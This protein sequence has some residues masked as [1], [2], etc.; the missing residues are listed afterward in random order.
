MSET[1]DRR[2]FLASVL[3]W[4]G[5][6]AGYGLGLKHF[7]EYLVPLGAKTRYRELFVGPFIKWMMLATP[8]MLVILV[9]AWLFM[10][11]LFKS[12][13]KELALVIPSSWDRSTS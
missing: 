12:R 3:M 2:G 4:L 6:A 1:K 5:V 7:L 11:L 9:F 10:G 8:G 13:E